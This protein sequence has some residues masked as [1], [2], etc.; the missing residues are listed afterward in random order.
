MP[1]APLAG[2]SSADGARARRR[3]RDPTSS[4]APITGSLMSLERD[5]RIL[6][7]PHNLALGRNGREQGRGSE[8]FICT[9]V[10]AANDNNDKFNGYDI[11]VVVARRRGRPALGEQQW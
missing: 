4:L 7:R 5:G 2:H 3:A 6:R 9:G 8:R 10:N 11:R 1:P